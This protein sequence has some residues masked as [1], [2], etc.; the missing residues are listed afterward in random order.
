MSDAKSVYG[1]GGF[2]IASSIFYWSLGVAWRLQISQELQLFLL[3]L[4]IGCFGSCVYAL[5]S[6]ADYQGDQ[7]LT[8]TW[9]LFYLVQPVEGA[10][11]A[12]L[13]Y[14]CIRGGFLSVGGADGKAVNQ[15]GICAVAGLSGA[16]SDIAFSKLREM[17]EV[18]FRPKDDRGGKLPL[19]QIQTSSLVPAKVGQLYKGAI[20]ATGAKP[21]LQWSVTPNLPSGLTLDGKTGAITGMPAGASAEAP[22]TFTVTDSSMP[23]ATATVQIKFRVD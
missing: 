23:Q 21:P 8:T 15:F 16:F 18:L 1:V 10:G 11:I 7:K 9:I 12:L 13:T 20:E 6:L 4:F 3:V 2:E 22:Y 17:F 14:L 19:P 5:K